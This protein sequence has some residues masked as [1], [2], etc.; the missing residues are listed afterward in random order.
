[1]LRVLINDIYDHE[2]RLF[3]SGFELVKKGSKKAI[4]IKI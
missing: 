2:K 3:K 4:Y 1:M